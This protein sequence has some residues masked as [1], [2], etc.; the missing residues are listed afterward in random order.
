MQD[1]RKHFGALLDLSVCCLIFHHV[2]SCA[3]FEPPSA[4]WSLDR[5]GPK[6]RFLFGSFW[7]YCSSKDVNVGMLEKDVCLLAHL[8]ASSCF[9]EIYI[10]YQMHCSICSLGFCFCVVRNTSLECSIQLMSC[11]CY[12]CCWVA[13]NS[14]V[15]VPG[16]TGC[17]GL[18]GC[19][20]WLQH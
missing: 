6:G 4:Q 15:Q 10:W 1:L 8:Y 12:W 9:S 7:S 11:C 20:I 17:R 19:K 16:L 18:Q 14:G 3:V 13:S 2:L 5:W